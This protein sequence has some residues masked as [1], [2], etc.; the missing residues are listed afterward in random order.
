MGAKE[1]QDW[2]IINGRYPVIDHV[3]VAWGAEHVMCMRCCS[4]VNQ[5]PH[6]PDTCPGLGSDFLFRYIGFTSFVISRGH[7]I[8]HETGLWNER[9]ESKC[10]CKNCGLHI[11]DKRMYKRCETNLAKSRFPSFDLLVLGGKLQAGAFLTFETY[12]E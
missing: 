4:I 11:S 1:S 2:P 10:I 9:D 7:D 12:N 5:G 8:P 6:T 3:N